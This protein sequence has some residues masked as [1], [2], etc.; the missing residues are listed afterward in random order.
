MGGLVY[1]ILCMS[2]IGAVVVLEAWPVYVLFSSRLYD[3]SL[4]IPMLAGVVGSLATA[5]ALT[6]AVFG[7]STRYGMQRLETIEP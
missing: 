2:F 3:V 1:M 6:V 5:L 7:L 4:S